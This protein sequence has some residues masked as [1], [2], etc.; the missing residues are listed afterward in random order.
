L[1]SE[2]AALFMKCSIYLFALLFL[3]LLTN[4]VSRADVGETYQLKETRNALLIK[5]G[6]DV[7]ADS[8]L[9]KE[10]LLLKLKYY[11]NCLKIDEK[12][13]SSYDSTINREISNGYT[14]LHTHKILVIFI[15]GCF[16]A[17]ILSLYFIHLLNKA[18]QP[19]LNY[20]ASGF[21]NNLNILLK[22]IFL[23]FNPIKGTESK[24]MGL[25]NLVIF[26]ILFMFLT[27]IGYL[28][29][30]LGVISLN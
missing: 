13:F 4:F 11:D 20:V 28:L 18:R 3:N 14:D 8:I 29:Q 12:I 7:S 6:R 23:L 21:F 5:A 30:M 17:L 10:Q 1:R 15:F 16:L 9:T 24:R 19:G 25:T 27:V 26:S 2:N 22:G